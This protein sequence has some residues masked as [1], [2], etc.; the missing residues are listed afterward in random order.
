MFHRVITLTTDFGTDSPYVAQMKASILAINVEARIVDITHAIPAQQISQG[1]AALRDTIFYFPPDTIHVAVVDPGVGTN[2]PILLAQFGSQWV[3]APDN[4][5]IGGLAIH[6]PPRTVYSISNQDLWRQP[7]SNTFHGRD[8]MAPVAAHLSG[9]VPHEN[10]GPK[11]TNYKTPDWPM[12]ERQGASLLGEV[13]WIDHFGNLITNISR[14]DCT[15]FNHENCTICC[16]N[17]EWTGIV[18]TYGVRPM[19]SR[20]ALFGSNNHLE[21]AISCGNAARALGIKLGDTV[22]LS[23]R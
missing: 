5:L 2:R 7:L 12:T 1:V 15:T 8:I 3:I 21:L 22:T 14:N 23:P 13:V 17:Q 18:A 11:T 6:E 20:V 9:G 19:G 4:G 10:V 16:R